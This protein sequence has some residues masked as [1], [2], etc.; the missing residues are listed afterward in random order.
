MGV[1]DETSDQGD[2]AISTRFLIDASGRQGHLCRMLDLPGVKYDQL[3]GVGA[4][5]HFKEPKIIAQELFIETVKQGSR[6]VLAKKDLMIL[7]FSCR[8]LPELKKDW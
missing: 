3:V 5:L 8:N 2:F 6:T 4:F 1:A 7:N